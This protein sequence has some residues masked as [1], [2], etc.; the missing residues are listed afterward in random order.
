MFLEI[1]SALVIS[2]AIAQEKERVVPESHFSMP[3]VC[4]N[5]HDIEE[6]LYRGYFENVAFKSKSVMLKTDEKNLVF[7]FDPEKMEVLLGDATHKPEYLREVKKGH[8][9]SIKF[10]EKNGEKVATHFEIKPPA[11][12]PPEKIIKMDE[13]E[14]YLY[15]NAGKYYLFDSRPAPRFQEGY[16]PTAVNLPLFAWKK[17]A[18]AKLPKEKDA[19]IIFYC[20]GLTCQLSPKSGKNAEK[21]GYLNYKVYH[22][23]MPDWSKK[24]F[25]LLTPQFMKETFLDKDIPHILFDVRKNSKDG[26]IKGAVAFDKKLIKTLPKADKKAPI[27]VYGDDEKETETIANEIVKSGQMNVKVIVGGMKGWMDASYPV[28]K[29]EIGSKVIY[30]PKL[31]EGELPPEE[32]L[33][34][35]KEEGKDYLILDVRN[36]DEANTGMIKHAKLI[37]AE[38]LEQ[39]IAEV[40]TDKL[41]ITHCAT[42]VR[43]EMAYHTLKGKGIKAKFLNSEIAIDKSG[44]IK[45]PGIVTD[46]PAPVKKKKAK[47]A[48]GGC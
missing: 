31:R 26:F 48:G 30:V 32:F 1:V 8:E 43:A 21:M 24:H 29:G 35:A 40:P 33:K 47:A 27:M 13:L 28:E 44:K 41:I 17:M 23:G 5:C 25:A 12:I 45:I 16:I 19:L 20:G 22:A 2:E 6:G 14:K 46:L 36:K 10:E 9:V 38:E 42:G 4:L 7:K 34:H 37:P 39:R 3:K 11:E 15:G 18:E